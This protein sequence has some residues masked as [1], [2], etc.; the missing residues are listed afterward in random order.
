MPGGS[1]VD[2]SL[3]GVGVEGGDLELRSQRCPVGHV[4]NH[5]T[6]REAGPFGRRSALNGAEAIDVDDCRG[7][8]SADGC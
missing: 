6:E 8:V 5:L 1:A 2:G 4:D 3:L 7:R